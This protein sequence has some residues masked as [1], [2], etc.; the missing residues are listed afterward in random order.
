M[1][2]IQTIRNKALSEIRGQLDQNQQAVFDQW[3]A[4]RQSENERK[5]EMLKSVD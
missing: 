3:S 1:D 5:K 2:E 4:Q